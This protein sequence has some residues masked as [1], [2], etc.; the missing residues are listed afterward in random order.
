MRCS[1]LIP[2]FLMFV[3]VSP[4]VSQVDARIASLSRQL[5]QGQD[6]QARSKAA[7]GLGASDDPE[8]LPPLCEGLKDPSEQVRAAAAQALGKLEELAG[9]DCLKARKGETDAATKTAIQTSLKVLQSLK[10][11]HPKLYVSL[12]ELKDKSGQVKPEVLRVT[13]AR[14]RRKLTKMGAWLAPAK[15]N[16]AAAL[17]VLRKFGVRGYRLQGE[18]HE[19]ESG[20]LRVTIVCI[21]YPD[22]ALLGDVELQASG[23]K[24]EDLLKAL[25]P[26]II[27]E[28]ADT[29]EWDT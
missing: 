22:Q 23:A 5:G 15:E 14:M 29:F 4:A 6:P 18:I 3:V 19:T 10:E 17:G 24:P 2:F 20:G 25:A 27:E 11:Q 7:S 16:K 26:R 12:V 13:E 8:A 21:S 1:P 9:L 28:A